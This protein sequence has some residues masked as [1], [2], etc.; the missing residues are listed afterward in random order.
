MNPEP[1]WTLATWEGSR[2]QQHRD[3]LALSFRRKLEVIEQLGEVAT[4][5]AA[6]RT[7]RGLPVRLPEGRKN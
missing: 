3:F 4:L 2:R 1:D 7:A 5:F 6:W